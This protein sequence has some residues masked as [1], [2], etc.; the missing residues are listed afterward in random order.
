MSRVVGLGAVEDGAVEFFCPG[1][2]ADVE[3]RNWRF[4]GR[5]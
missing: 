1:A 2:Y 5:R 4:G 3:V